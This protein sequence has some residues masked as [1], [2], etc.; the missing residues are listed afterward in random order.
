MR[1]ARSTAEYESE[2]C[3]NLRAGGRCRA[4]H[5]D[6]TAE[7]E[8]EECTNLRAGGRCRAAHSDNGEE[9]SENSAEHSGIRE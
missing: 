7:Y 5:S 8:S 9:S 2:E 3:T 1:T 6:N 4:A